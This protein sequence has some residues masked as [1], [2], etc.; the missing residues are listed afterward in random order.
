MEAVICDLERTRQGTSPRKETQAYDILLLAVSELTFR[1]SVA[2]Y[3]ANVYIILCALGA[4][5]N[6]GTHANVKHSA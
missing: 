4:K 3:A 5:A 2:A 6:D 1:R